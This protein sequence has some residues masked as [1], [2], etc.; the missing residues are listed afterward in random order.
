MNEPPRLRDEPYSALER[1]LLD[2]GRSYSASDST[3]RRA[4]AALGVA[5]LATSGSAAASSLSSLTKS[6]LTKWGAVAV[7]AGGGALAAAHY[8]RQAP[9]T[10]AASG[11]LGAPLTAATAAVPAA[12]PPAIEGAPVAPDGDAVPVVEASAIPTAAPNAP[13]VEAKAAQAAPAALAAEL[14]ALDAV[15][16]SLRA[17]NP[18]AALSALDAYSRSFPRGKL[19]LEAEVLRIDAL[20]KSGQTAAARSR[21]EAFIK[22]H[23]DSVLASRVRS[24]VGL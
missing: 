24:S 6:G 17:G 22:R 5:G 14:S 18:S 1:S 15:R 23:P 13:R 20:A 11:A 10:T 7:L 9:S 16:G 2:A 21:A 19:G 3:R 8:L 12:A 4:L